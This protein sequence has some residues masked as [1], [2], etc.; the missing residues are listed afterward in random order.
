MWSDLRVTNANGFGRSLQPAYD[1]SNLRLGIQAPNDRWTAEVYATN[2]FDKNAIIY[3][4]TSNYDHHNTTNLPRVIGLRLSYR[5]G[6]G[7]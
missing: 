2:L 5:W 1:I 7:E 3:T 4:N 6:K